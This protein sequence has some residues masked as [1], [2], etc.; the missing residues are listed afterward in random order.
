MIAGPRDDRPR[1]KADKTGPMLSLREDGKVLLGRGA[2]RVAGVA[3]ACRR[4]DRRRRDERGRRS[5]HRLVSRT[6]PSLTPQLV[7]GGT[8]GQLWSAPGRRP[9]L[10]AAAA[11][12]ERDAARRHREQQG[13]RPQSRHGRTA[14]DERTSARRGTRPTSA[15]A[16]SRRSIGVTATPVID[17]A[18][19]TAYLT[20]KTYVSGRGRPLV[21]GR[22]RRR[23]R[24][25]RS[26]ASP[27]G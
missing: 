14:V 3:R 11:V 21:H 12:A 2:D 16:T 20:H 18:T 24:R 23:H 8:F 25:R 4:S 22:G 7:S 26:P 1:A 13:L 27:S 19:N 15:A 5:A 6:K 10:R 9:G 17:P